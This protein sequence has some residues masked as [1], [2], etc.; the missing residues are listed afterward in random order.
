MVRNITAYLRRKVD[1]PKDRRNTKSHCLVTIVQT[2]TMKFIKQLSE[3]IITLVFQDLHFLGCHFV[4][5]PVCI[6]RMVS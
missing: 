3:Q 6:I 5:Q 4:F 1:P 2:G